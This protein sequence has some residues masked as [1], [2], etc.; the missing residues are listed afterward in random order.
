MGP[1]SQEWGEK[2]IEYCCVVVRAYFAAGIMSVGGIDCKAS[3]WAGKLLRLQQSG[4]Q[5]GSDSSQARIVE[6]TVVVEFIV[7]SSEK[8]SS[9]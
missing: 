8:W 3:S 5:C 2:L 7:V 4:S 1:T 9:S 6:L